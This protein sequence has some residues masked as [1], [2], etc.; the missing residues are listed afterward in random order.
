MNKLVD[1]IRL[2]PVLF[3]WA[4]YAATFQEYQK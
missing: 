2:Q 3:S 4:G 1:K